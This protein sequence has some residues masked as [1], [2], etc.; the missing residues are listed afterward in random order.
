MKEFNP[1]DDIITIEGI[2]KLWKLKQRGKPL[3]EFYDIQIKNYIEWKKIAEVDA[4][5]KLDK[6]VKQRK[7]AEMVAAELGV[8]L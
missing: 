4:V 1:R 3:P 2:W 7:E 8:K 5:L 6:I